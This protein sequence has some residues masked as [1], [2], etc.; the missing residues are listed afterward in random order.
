M[1]A[2]LGVITD[3]DRFIALGNLLEAFTNI[4]RGDIAAVFTEQTS[5]AL[6]DA[7]GWSALSDVSGV[8][9]GS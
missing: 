9:S 1:D 8:L 6:S 4:I 7:D 3:P 5:S 2:I